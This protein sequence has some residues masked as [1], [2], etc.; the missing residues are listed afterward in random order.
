MGDSSNTEIGTNPSRNPLK[1]IFVG[2]G[3]PERLEAVMAKQ[4]TRRDFLKG[5]AVVIAGG[6]LS[7]CGEK[8]TQD[9]APLY[10]KKL[11]S[12]E[13]ISFIEVS[14]GQNLPFY[15]GHGNK[16]NIVHIAYDGFFS[17]FDSLCQRHDGNT[18]DRLPFHSGSE[19]TRHVGE[20]VENRLYHVKP[21]PKI[22]E[23]ITIGVYRKAGQLTN[24]AEGN[25]R[26]FP[27]DTEIFGF[28]TIVAPSDYILDGTPVLTEINENCNETDHWMNLVGFGLGWAVG[29]LK[30]REGK[31]PE[32]RFLGYVR[33][34]RALEI[35]P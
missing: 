32:F 19:T 28:L 10:P 22:P 2:E 8:P 16:Q 13:N 31:Y 34:A 23:D 14:D 21:N 20:I 17:D 6:M 27:K 12:R 35:V 4:T 25:R 15:Y 1:Q 11:A 7:S 26:D 24:M 29:T 5:T 9:D 33:D 18:I 3:R 30:P